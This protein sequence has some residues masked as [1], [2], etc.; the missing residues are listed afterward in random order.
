LICSKNLKSN[1][2]LNKCIKIVN[3]RKIILNRGHSSDKPDRIEWEKIDWIRVKTN[4][5]IK[6]LLIGKIEVPL[7]EIITQINLIIII[8]GLQEIIPLLMIKIIIITIKIT[9][10]ITNHLINKKNL[11]YRIRINR[12]ILLG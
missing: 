12:C 2:Y 6:S 7:E 1:K 8:G 10:I 3:S 4:L 9:I 5:T 11:L